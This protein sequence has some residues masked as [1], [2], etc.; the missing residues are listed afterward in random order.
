MAQTLFEAL[1]PGLITSVFSEKMNG[2][3]E[4]FPSEF[5]T[6][7]QDIEEPFG[8][9][10]IVSGDNK[11][12]PITGYDSPSGREDLSGFDRK[13]FNALNVRRHFTLNSTTIRRLKD[14]SNT[15]LQAVEMGR[16]R[17]SIDRIAGHVRGSVAGSVLAMLIGELKYTPAADGATI[18]PV[19]GTVTHDYGIPATHKDQINLNAVIGGAAGNI[20]GIKWDTTSSTPIQDVVDIAS[21]AM[22][23]TGKPLAYAVYGA[24]IP[25][26]LQKNDNF[27]TWVQYNISFQNAFM[28]GD[29]PNGFGGIPNWIPARNMFAE[30]A[31]STDSSRSYINFVDPNKIIFFPAIDNSWYEMYRVAVDVPS[32]VDVVGGG[33]SAWMAALNSL[34]TTFG[35]F[36]YAIAQGDPVSCKVVL[37]NSWFPA[38]KNP[39]CVFIAD[40]DF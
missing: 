35:P 9:Y 20:I 13:P 22:R 21:A 10:V 36:G 14:M 24:N 39:K 8:S 18:D 1:D 12:A 26:Y 19:N 4:A 38:L 3:P 23:I 16:I 29:V 2:V 30:A 5:L 31:S 25:G 40:V 32:T 33:E 28:N 34:N 11:M 6:V 17:N 27:K 7:T 37:G 15:S